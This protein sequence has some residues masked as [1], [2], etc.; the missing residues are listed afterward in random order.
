MAQNEIN[1]DKQQDIKRRIRYL[2]E[3]Q[4]AIKD[5][6][7]KTAHYAGL[8]AKRLGERIA[9]HT[10]QEEEN[11]RRKFPNIDFSIPSP[12]PKQSDSEVK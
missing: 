4:R 11:L 2:T 7:P 10:Y 9:T 12:R 3:M 1:P 8:E 6:L 5:G